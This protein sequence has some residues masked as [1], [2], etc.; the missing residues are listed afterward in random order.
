MDVPPALQQ[1]PH[2]RWA[3]WALRAGYG[4][5]SV[6]FVGLVVVL[7]GLTPWVLAAGVIGWLTAAAVTLSAF[8][9][10]RSELPEPRP[11]LWSMRLM[12]IHDSVHTLPST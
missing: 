1:N 7:L 4:A 10:S 2:W 8:F 3:V 12:L 9:W 5:L 11:G 6:A